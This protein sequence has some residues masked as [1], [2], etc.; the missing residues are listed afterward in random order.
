MSPH[1][2]CRASV[3]NPQTWGTFEE[4]VNAANGG[5]VGFV[6]TDSDPY[7]IVDLDDKVLNPANEEELATHQRILS[8]FQSYSERSKSGRGWHIVV[9]ASTSTG[10]K[11]KTVEVYSSGRFIVLTGDTMGATLPIQE[12]QWLVDY[13]IGTMPSCAR[14]L[15]LDESG[16]EPLTDSEL[17][18]VAS[19]A[20][21]GDKFLDLCNTPAEIQAKRYGSQSEAD[22][23]LLSCLCFW[24]RNNEQVRRIFRCSALGQRAKATINNVYLNRSLAYIRANE[25]PLVD[26][27]GISRPEDSTSSDVVEDC[28]E[29][30]EEFVYPPGFTGELVRWFMQIVPRPVVEMETAAAIAF[31]AGLLGRAYNYSGT[32]LNQYVMLLGKT[33]TGKEGMATAIGTLVANI[34]PTIPMIDEMVGPSAFASGQAILKTIAKKP[35]FLSILGEF[36]LTLQSLS[37]PRNPTSLIYRKVLLD[38][39]SKSGSRQVMHSSAYS[40][41]EKNV[42]SIASPSMSLL[43]EGTPGTFFEGLNASHIRDGLLP[44]FLMI[45]YQGKRVPRNSDVSTPCPSNVLTQCITLASAAFHLQQTQQV[46]EVECEP[47]A[48]V[49]LDEMDR[50]SDDLIN[51]SHEIGDDNEAELWN[52]SHLK[53]L[54]LSALLAVADNPHNPTITTAHAEWAIKTVQ[55][56]IS[57]LMAR[58]QSG[59]VGVGDSKQ[60][61]DVKRAIKQYLSS[62]PEKLQAQYAIPAA[63]RGAGLVPYLYIQRRTATLSA[64]VHDRLGAS[65]ALKRCIDGLISTGELE[66]LPKHQIAALGFSGRVFKPN[67]QD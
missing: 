67:I 64:F 57:M 1:N 66:E 7:A 49:L 41:S 8:G 31:L 38:V 14:E 45:H 56:D 28:G 32:G 52:R 39:F 23:A 35:C 18:E 61:S 6:L 51:N 65:A 30:E 50:L 13:L 58:F 59:D 22:M 33:G 37:D 20:A 5:H 25:I 54:K 40:D 2:R 53:M 29:V 21:N 17:F 10:R 27:P 44:R 11:T 4:A 16:P 15:E 19:N 62:D 24:T 34:R 63:L 36:G 55:K 48:K 9:R 12:R 3:D 26:I 42:Q 60:F 47:A 43:C 46:I